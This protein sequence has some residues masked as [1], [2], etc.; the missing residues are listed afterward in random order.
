M[1]LDGLTEAPP[2]PGENVDR[3]RAKTPSAINYRIDQASMKR[4]WFYA[5]Q[6][7]AEISRR[8]QELDREWDLERYV[9]TKAAS[10][11]LAGVVLGGTVDKRW[12]IVPAVVLGMLLQH[13]LCRSSA[14]VVLLRRIGIRTRREIDAEKYALKMLRGDFDALKA[15]SEETHRA[16]EALRLSRL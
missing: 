11:A 10:L 15:I 6:P 16:I 8:I 4:I 9:E 7:K 1:Q 3:V 14:Q 5:R 12:L 2:E 13:G